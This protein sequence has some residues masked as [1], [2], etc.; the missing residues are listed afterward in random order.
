[1]ETMESYRHA[2]DG[3]DAVL[4]AVP[5]DGWD[6]PSACAQWTVRDV[7]GHVIWGQEQLRHWATGQEY[8]GTT[9]APG[10]PHPGEL[11]GDD[12][13]ATW[14]AARARCAETL[15]D[16][17]LGRTVSITGLGDIPLAGVVTLLVTDHLA[18]TWDIGHALGLDVRLAPELVTGSFAWAR[19]NMVRA[20]GYFGPEL[21]PPP[22][23]DE[24]TRWLAFL[25]RACWEPVT[26]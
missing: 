15:T 7:A 20:P 4:A 23:A 22:D 1:M 12:P 9:G 6:K 25:G 16:E 11:T 3:F 14:R 24:Q 26:A 5:A 10:T 21:T 19:A 13:V 8:T 2:Q 17:A 18:H